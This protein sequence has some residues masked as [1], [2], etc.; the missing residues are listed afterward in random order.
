MYKKKIILSIL[1][2]INTVLGQEISQFQ[3]N[4]LSSLKSVKTE[5]GK[6]L[7]WLLKSQKV[8]IS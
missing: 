5:I 6:K 8:L 4:L 3:K 2:I 7:V 1:L